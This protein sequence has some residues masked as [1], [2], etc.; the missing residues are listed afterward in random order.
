LFR[1]NNLFK[2]NL[3]ITIL[4]YKKTKIIC[5]IGPAS[6]SVDILVKLINAG[7]DC[8]R[9][10]F[11]HGTYETHREYIKNIRKAA[12]LTN[13]HIPI[14]QDLS[15]PKIRIGKIVNGKMEI[16][17][18]DD[19]IISAKE[20]IG[21]NKII[22]T[23]YKNIIND[24]KKNETILLDDGKLKL[25]ITS[26][27]KSKRLLLC[28]VIKGGIL[29]EHKGLNLPDTKISLPSLTEKDLSDIKFGVE[30]SVDLVALSFVRRAKDI[31]ELKNVLKKYKSEVPVIAKI[32]KPEAI[33][34]IDEIIKV[35][36]IIMVAR[37][38]LGVEVSPEDVPVLQKMIIKK[39]NNSL[40][41]VITATQML[42]SMINNILPTRAEA[43]D[44]ANAILDGTDC[45]ML[46][47]ETSTGMNPV[48]VVET[49]DKINE[50]TELIKK[51]VEENNH[52]KLKS[53]LCNIT[54]S[55]S[56]IAGRINAKA[57]IT[58]SHTGKSPILLSSH[59]CKSDI[60]AIVRNENIQTRCSL[61]WGVNPILDSK[62]SFTDK[63]GLIKFL[64]DK[65]YLQKN[66][67][68]ILIENTNL[69]ENESANALQIIKV[70]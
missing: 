57:I 70:K 18:T 47:G 34:N 1:I 8:A 58:L 49:M 14:L 28:K 25:I 64:K 52:S 55:A 43:S 15:G 27:D 9:L 45:V 26:I 54:N 44:V 65:G 59:R 67:I 50:K 48:L 30:N 35:S 4:I 42:E 23:N 11:S 37:G 2:I 31:I 32:E 16:K 19:I 69:S 6:G 3:I 20:V 56:E 29:S 13:T 53:F 7:M 12:K 17:E 61:I 62:I 38:D 60:I 36:D 10:N 51:P 63:P 24:V 22:S 39:C 46:S 41:P 40:K 33:N 5:T 21:N 66:D 68:A